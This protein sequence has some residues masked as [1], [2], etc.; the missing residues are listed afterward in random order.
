[1]NFYFIFF[2]LISI[3]TIKCYPSNSFNSELNRTNLNLITKSSDVFLSRSIRDVSDESENKSLSTGSAEVPAD[4]NANLDHEMSD[5]KETSESFSSHPGDHSARPPSY[6]LQL[7]MYSYKPKS[8]HLFARELGVKKILIGVDYKEKGPYD[9]YIVRIRY[10]GHE[11]YS[12]NKM[13]IHKNETNELILKKFLDAQ[14]IICVTLFSLSASEYPPISTSDMCI[15]VTAG[16]TPH[17]G[18]HRSA[19]GLLSPLLVAVAAVLLACI[20]IGQNLKDLYNQRKKKLQATID[21]PKLDLKKS[22]TKAQFDELMRVP[23]DPRMQTAAQK[24]Q[25]VE[26]KSFGD[27]TD[28]DCV[29]LDNKKRYSIDQL[30]DL[31]QI[32]RASRLNSVDLTSLQSIGRLSTKKPW[33]YQN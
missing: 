7:H 11:E 21:S 19:T 4:E 15:D 30:R 29:Y 28:P 9:K 17:I 3:K 1:M 13:K 16:E 2:I 25:I 27:L 32:R 18:G 33:V 20:V 5:Y 23:E 14:Y 10:H 31:D 12:T 22:K 8:F 24:C 26:N 6:Q